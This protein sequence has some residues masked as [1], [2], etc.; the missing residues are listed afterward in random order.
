M[1]IPGFGN[2]QSY[3]KVRLLAGTA[4]SGAHTLPES[5]V[6]IGDRVTIKSGVYIWDNIIIEDDVFIG[7]VSL[8]QMISIQDQNVMIKNFFPPILKKAHPLAL[9]QRYYLV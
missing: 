6:T 8:S 5:R 4:I 3:L 2:F 7:P 9:M 1:K